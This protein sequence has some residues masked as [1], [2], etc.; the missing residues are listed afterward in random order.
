M[1]KE[2]VVKKILMKALV[3]FPIGVTLLIIAYASVYFISGEDT[4]NAELYQ[5]H[6]INTLISQIASVG[7]AGYLISISLHTMSILQSKNLE[8]KLMTAHPYKSISAIALSFFCISIIFCL[9][10]GNEKIFTENIITLN[11]IILVIIYV[12]IGI[13]F[14]MKIFIEQHLVKEINQ[15]IKKRNFQ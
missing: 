15:R 6:N 1:K 13:V 2:N 12:F 11:M 5:L 14:A 3:G 4:F 7:I 10:L 8:K 9:I